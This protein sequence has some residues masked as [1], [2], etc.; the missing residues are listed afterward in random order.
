ML[1]NGFA[2]QQDI[3]IIFKEFSGDMFTKEH[4]HKALMNLYWVNV[5][6]HLFNSKN[7][8]LYLII[9]NILNNQETKSKQHLKMPEYSF[10]ISC[11]LSMEILVSMSEEYPPN[12]TVGYDII[13]YNDLLKI[14][15]FP[16]DKYFLTNSIHTYCKDIEEYLIEHNLELYDILSDFSRDYYED[17]EPHK[18]I[19]K[20]IIDHI[21]YK[22]L[23]D[24]YQI[25]FVE[26]FSEVL[27][28][29]LRQTV[30]KEGHSCMEEFK[31]C[32]EEIIL[33]EL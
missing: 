7:K 17:K 3:K 31:W 32:C 14:A 21:N 29:Y 10:K 30:S 6:Q 16:T 23:E 27:Y 24:Q 8:P 20:G 15:T 1:G 19:K 9:K 22:I 11:D 2:H 18:T 12:E 25:L 28:N 33:N 26:E 5:E 4:F 13:M